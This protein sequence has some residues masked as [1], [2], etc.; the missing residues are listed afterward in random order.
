MTCPKCRGQM[1]SYERNLVVIDQCEDCR[2]L[3][4]DRGE[5]DK[6]IAAEGQWN[7]ASA[8]QPGAGQPPSP[9]QR[10]YPAREYPTREY[11]SREH[12]EHPPR[13]YGHGPQA[14]YGKRKKRSFLEDLFD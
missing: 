6:L 8:N 12:R 10:D 11:S 9:P 4:L 7:S 3:F 14:G 13:D 5:L 2:G 1:N